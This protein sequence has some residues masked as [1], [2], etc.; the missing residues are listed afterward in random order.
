[1]KVDDVIYNSLDCY[2]LNDQP[3]TCGLCG[4]RTDF[5]EINDGMQIHECLNLDCRYKFITEYE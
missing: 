4:A 3:M 2:I 5:A 1:M